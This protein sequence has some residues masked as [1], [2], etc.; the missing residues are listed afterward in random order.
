MQGSQG[1]SNNRE[2]SQA[3]EDL[4]KSNWDKIVPSFEEMELKYDLLRGVFGYGYEK[5]SAIQSKAI[6][7]L[8]MRRDVIGQAQSGSGKT[9][10]FVIGMLQNIDTTQLIPQAVVVAPTRELATQIKDV[11][12]GLGVYL[13][14]RI[15]LCTGGT[16]VSE[17]RRL[18]GEGVNVVVGTP[19]RIRDLV[20]RNALQLGSL[21]MLIIDEADELLSMGFIEQ[22]NEITKAIPPD[23]QIALFS[24]TIAPGVIKLASTILRDPVTILVRKEELTLEGIKQYYISC[25]NE[26]RKFDTLDEL[27]GNIDINQCIIYANTKERV[28]KLEADLKAK[29]FIVSCIHS[30][31]DQEK[32]NEVMREFRS[33][34]SRILVS[35]DLLA[36]GIDVHQVGLVV[37]YELPPKKENYIHRI[38]R[39]GR[40]GR[41]G[42]AIN[43]ITPNEV[44]YMTEIQS[45]YQTQILE[46]PQDLS[47]LEN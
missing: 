45:F 27:F 22:L 29:E 23:C 47:E 46:L 17:D 8:T 37:N 4:F 18:I 5:P 13:N 14:V 21:K 25:G 1:E 20:Q 30:N 35:T 24:A 6:I 43:L 11:I 33:G 41:R 15:Q 40:Y 7:P 28:M 12:K 10:T 38:G 36:R 2:P 3:E 31:L 16:L 34:V 9:A 44:T 32:R 26:A 39:S 42:I 19:G